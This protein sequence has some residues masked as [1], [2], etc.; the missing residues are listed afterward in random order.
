MNKIKTILKSFITIVLVPVLAIGGIFAVSPVA[1]MCF[2]GISNPLMGFPALIMMIPWGVFFCIVFFVGVGTMRTVTG[3]PPLAMIAPIPS[4]VVYSFGN[5]GYSIGTGKGRGGGIVFA[6]IRFVLAIPFA[7]LVWLII[8]IIILF[9]E[10]MEN[11]MN[12]A[13]DT[14]LKNIKEWYKWALLFFVIFPLIVVGFNAIENAVYSPKHIDISINQ[15][16]ST[17]YDLYSPSEHFTLS[18][19]INA[20]GKDIKEIDGEWLFENTKTGK[21]YVMEA[22]EFVPYD[23]HWDMEDKNTDHSFEVSLSVPISSDEYEE[24]FSCDFED[25]K[26]VCKIKSISFDCNIPILGDF[27]FSTIDNEYKDGYVCA[28]LF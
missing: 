20:N 18:Y 10:K 14:F 8:S 12:T 6:I 15:F 16:E 13:F 2:G 26:I 11:R 27:L 24:I 28:T 23:F 17:G 25:L 19:S 3:M 22:D 5:G 4:F 1:K 21:T 9:S 7:I